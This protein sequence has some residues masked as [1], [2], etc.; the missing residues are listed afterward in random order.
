MIVDHKYKVDVGQPMVPRYLPE[1]LF[2]SDKVADRFVISLTD[3]FT[4]INAEG[5][6]TAYFV[7]EETGETVALTD[8]GITEGKLYC[9]LDSACYAI[10]GRCA[11]VIQLDYNNSRKT[12]FMGHTKVVPTITDVYVDPGD[13]IGNISELIAKSEQL[14]EDLVVALDAAVAY[15]NQIEQLID[16]A[17]GQISILAD[18]SIHH[19]IQLEEPTV[20]LRNGDLW[21]VKDLLTWEVFAQK[22]GGADRTWE[23][24]SE[25]NW[26]QTMNMGDV[27][28]T[29]T[30]FKG[31]WLL[32]S[33]VSVEDFISAENENF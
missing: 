30:Y 3:G 12:F 17:T 15:S 16:E 9:V 20:N 8:R 6:V 22:E 32:M 27:G 13:T 7:R 25:Y 5:V 4:P 21:T 23:D 19:Y 33:S 28:V 14:Y 18:T 31:L 10:T 24:A 26:A 29:K 2:Y 11:I 1:P